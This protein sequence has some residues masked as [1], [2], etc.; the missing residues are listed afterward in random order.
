[1]IRRLMESIKN[2]FSMKPFPQYI[3]SDRYD[4]GPSCLKII[5]QYY[6]RKLNIE[7]L[8]TI[9]R[10]GP[11]GVS[12]DGIITGAEDL[13]I[14][15]FPAMVSFESLKEE[16][17]LPC[18]AFWRD[19][20]F[21]VVYKVTKSHVYV[22]DPSFGRVKYTINEFLQGWYNKPKYN[23]DD[24]GVLILLEPSADFYT[25]G[26]A[27]EIS[28]IRTIVPYL[29][30]YRRYLTQIVV[31][32]I[33][34]V[35]IQLLLPFITQSLV[36]K[37]I[38]IGDI[39]FVYVLLAAQLTLFFS[40][41]LISMLRGWLLLYIGA[42]TSMLI[43]SD[44]LVKLLRK[45]ATFFDSKTPGDILQRINDSNRIESFLNATPE[46]FFSYINA[47]IFLFILGYYDMTIFA[48]FTGGTIIY[49]LWVWFFMKK[50][51]ELDFKRFDASS[52]INS[53]L[54]QMVNGIQEIL[55]NGSEKKHRWD[56]EKNRVKYYKNS[57]STLKLTQFQTLGGSVINE[58]KN[59]LITF[60]SAFLVINGE[61]TLGSMLAIQYIVGQINGPLLSLVSFFRNLQDAKLSIKRFN[62]VEFLTEHEKTLNDNKLVKLSKEPQDIV[63][64]NVSFSYS[65]LEDYVLKDLSLTIPKGKVTAIVGNSGGGK[66]TLMK[67]LLKL[68]LPTKGVISIGNTSIEHVNTTAWRSN[69]GTVMQDG[70]IF[71]D[72]IQ[73]NITESRSTEVVNLDM[74]VNS[75]NIA[76]LQELIN[77]LPSGF[78]S[79]VGPSGASGRSLSGGQRQRVLIARAI[80]KD[81]GYLFLD[82]A[83]SALDAN[84]EKDI[85][86]NL[87]A[88]QKDKTVVVIAHRLSTV[89]NA[90]QIVVL[91]N[92]E[93]KEIGTH[94]ELVKSRSYY[95]NLVKNQLE[96]GN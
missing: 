53:T 43:T 86:N 88:F 22:S 96:L 52:S 40:S 47:S 17:P 70:Y 77:E 48:I 13:G 66:T 35:F 21:L 7:H 15:G 54:I 1:M 65:G 63:L 37:G 30:N 16:V 90:D 81:P 50:R 75:I 20:H 91:D 51:E 24:N 89:K 67:L 42:R 80:Y 57:V 10:I 49:T 25:N 94:E 12:M 3:Q 61:L 84:N 55:I 58:L 87:E 18:I 27:K 39:D 9:C 73:N 45:S 64:K 26:N 31:G 95:Y 71:T 59:I 68:Y 85:V 33:V 92:G 8:R 44:Y 74:L 28:G 4:C 29:K 2:L 14:K 82:E 36:D 72:T 46:T 19:R 69:C 11:E 83:T 41:S 6:G 5:A 34:G 60:T 79:I 62:E 23:E 93:I 32:L 76:N 78:N 56:W 38:N